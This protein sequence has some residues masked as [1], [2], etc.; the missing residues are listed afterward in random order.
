MDT[1]TYPA[2]EVSDFV[3]ANLVAWRVDY[4]SETRLLRLFH[5]NWTPTLLFLDTRE[6][7]R[8]R[9]IGYLPPGILIAHMILA[10]GNAAFQT[11]RYGE[12]ENHYGRIARDF[13]ASEEAP[14]AL[15]FR[16]VARYKQSRDDADL[17]QAAREL[18][19]LYPESE[20]TLR[21]LPWV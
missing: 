20:W 17:E 5:I 8:Y 21:S 14:R 18:A 16:G 3:N 13:P 15:F 6:K 9:I 7:E 4:L 1:V 12:A 19:S 10:L 11:S 2:Q